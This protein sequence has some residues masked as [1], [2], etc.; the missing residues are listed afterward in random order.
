VVESFLV[1]IVVV[2]VAVV[3]QLMKAQRKG[4]TQFKWPTPKSWQLPPPGQGRQPMQVIQPAQGTRPPT[5]QLIQPMPGTPPPMQ[6]VVQP[7]PGTRPFMPQA[8]QPMQGHTPQRPAG[9]VPAPVA[10]P[11]SHVRPPQHRPPP[12]Q[13]P[14]PQDELDDRIRELMAKNMEVAAVR[15]L[16]DEAGMG[17]IEAQVYARALVAPESAAADADE[18]E[19]E[20]A[21]KPDAGERYTGSAAFGT[22]T[23]ERENENV[24]ASGWVDEPE[25]EDRSDID[26]LWKTVRDTGRLGS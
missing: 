9:W 1:A 14:A 2:V 12:H 16:C 21:T 11:P 17:I 5:A 20:P 6:Q 13:L 15:L 8:I 10:P 25:P 19:A 26:E 24:W 7:M 3:G 22:S 4:Q 18:E 23:F